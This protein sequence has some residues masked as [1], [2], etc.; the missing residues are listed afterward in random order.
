M[1]EPTQRSSEDDEELEVWGIR[2]GADDDVIA[3]LADRQEWPWSVFVAVA[4]FVREEPL[5]T[6]LAEA[7][8]EALGAVPG[9]TDVVHEDRE[10]WVVDGTPRGSDLVVAVD[11]ELDRLGDRIRPFLE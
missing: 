9:V 6:E 7:V 8:A 2:E 11:R 10:V 3:V 1:S 4:E 5:E